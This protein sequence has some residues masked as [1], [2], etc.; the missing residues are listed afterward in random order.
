MAKTGSSNAYLHSKRNGLLN[1]A[2]ELM[3]GAWGT[4]AGRC[5]GWGGH[6]WEVEGRGGLFSHA[7]GTSTPSQSPSLNPETDGRSPLHLPLPWDCHHC[8]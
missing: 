2:L 7:R 8:P 1:E 6:S 3:V 5:G 4:R